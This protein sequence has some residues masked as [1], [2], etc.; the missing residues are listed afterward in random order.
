VLGEIPTGIEW[1]GIAIVTA[2]LV[3][4]LTGQP[5]TRGLSK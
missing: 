1:I 5:E 4:L 3:L 2:G